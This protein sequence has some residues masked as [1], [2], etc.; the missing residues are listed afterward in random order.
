M[1]RTFGIKNVDRVARTI[2]KVFNDARTQRRMY[3]DIGKFTTNRIVATARTGKSLE[4][5]FDPQ[6]FPKLKESTIKR[7]ESLKRNNPFVL[8]EQFFRARFANVTLTGQLLESFRYRVQRSIVSFF[9]KDKRLPIYEGDE[10]SNNNVYDNLE[11][12]GFGFVGLD[13]K[14]QQRVKR[15]VLDQLRREIK[16]IFK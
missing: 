16:K 10:T 13:F 1:A 4:D 3:D 5:N 7:R 8:D 14:G 2:N 11:S 15:I 12:L 9:F 6:K